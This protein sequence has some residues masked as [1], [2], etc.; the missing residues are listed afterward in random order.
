[1]AYQPIIN[2]F[3]LSGEEAGGQPSYMDALL[4]GF[5]GTEEAAEAVNRPKKLQ[6]AL[7]QAQLKN[8]HD[9]TINKYLEPSEQARVQ[10]LQQSNALNPYRQQLLQAQIGRANRPEKKSKLEILLAYA[11]AQQDAQEQQ[12]KN[13]SFIPSLNGDNAGNPMPGTKKKEPSL[14]DR[15]IQHELDLATGDAGKKSIYN[16]I[17]HNK[18]YQAIKAAEEIRKQYPDIN[19]QPSPQYQK[20]IDLETRKQEGEQSL[21]EQRERRSS[22]LKPGETWVKDS[23]GKNIAINRDYSPAEKK[24]EKGRLF[25]NEVYPEILNA[26]AYYSGQGSLS[27]FEYDA[28]NYKNDKAAQKRID[29]YLTA[30]KLLPATSVKENAT[31]GGANTNQVYNRLIGSLDS[32]DLPKTAEKIVKQFQLPMEA[33]LR[34]GNKFQQILNRAT[35][36]SKNIPARHTEYLDNKRKGHIYDSKT[37]KVKEVMVSPQNWEAFSQAGGY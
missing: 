15:I 11:Q 37:K 27:K 35:D 34:S 12:Q 13:Q 30:I 29:N 31:V 25:F 16:P 32:S 10:G 4:K 6:E 3:R 8:A 26:T 17:E 28:F 22:G 2:A 36:K 1:M 24:E 9:R 23:S 14:R 33:Q 19:G 5:K 20:F 18:E 7:L 21:T